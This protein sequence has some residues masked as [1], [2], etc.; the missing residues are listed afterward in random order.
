[1][2]KVFRVSGTYK[3]LHHVQGFNIEIVAD[4]EPRARELVLSLIGSKHGVPRRLIKVLG[5]KD[6]PADQI[7][8]AAIRHQAGL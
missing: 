1:M 3:T 5:V 4:S 8:S 7:E 6:V 2:A